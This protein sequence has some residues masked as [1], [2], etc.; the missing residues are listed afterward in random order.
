MRV[1]A[2]VICLIGILPVVAQ[3]Q[4]VGLF[5]NDEQAYEGYTLFGPAQGT[6]V[7][8]I[9]NDGLVVHEW[10]TD[11]RPG[12]MGYLRDNG[13]LVRAARTD[14]DSPI[15]SG[16]LLQEFDWDGN[17]VWEFEPDP[18]T[19]LA[20]H[21]IEPLP[22]GNLLVVAWE[23]KTSA[24]AIAAGRQPLSA[25]EVWPDTILELRPI[26]PND[27]EIV[28]EWHVW[29]HLVQQIDPTADNFGLVWEHPELIDVNFRSTNTDWNHVN[30]V[31]YNP[32]L[33]Q[34]LISV[35][36][37]DEIWVIDHSTTTAEA[38]GHSGGV[39]GKG[40]DLLYRW[41]NPWTYRLGSRSDRKL[42]GQHDAQ[43]IAPGYPG[44]GNI[45]VFNNGH[46]AAGVGYS[47]VDEIVPPLDE[48]GSYSIA[49]GHPYGPPD[50][51]WSFMSTPRE[52]FYSAFISGAQRQPNGNTLICEGMSGH[53]F[54]VTPERDVVW[55]Y[56]N[57]IAIG[58]TTSQ[59]GP[60]AQNFVFK[61]RRYPVDHPA[62]GGRQLTP[63]D[64]IELFFA[65]FPAPDGSLTAFRLS[66]AG[67]TI[68]VEWDASSCA[69][70]DYN[71]IFGDLQQVSTYALSGAQC[72]IGFDGSYVWE[73][74]PADSLYFMVVGADDT[75]IYESSWG[76]DST[77]AE[78][79]G[80]AASFLCGTTTKIVSSTCEGGQGS[81]GAPLS[82]HGSIRGG[83]SSM[84]SR[85]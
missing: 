52:D 56:V 63:G 53:L 66:D 84:E 4:T 14:A 23:F 76:R 6:S 62:I 10:T 54:E 39:S 69:S 35:R 27:A 25:G 28:W 73:D 42:F 72:A 3:E 2:I 30:S 37:F 1:V 75:G 38:A 32:A 17:L 79:H 9:N 36:A 81:A 60:P 24:E 21:D 20:H 59:G 65:P 31:A 8:L 22:N 46:G 55:D 48:A 12:L 83:L 68:L 15:G 45:L 7:Y 85:Y 34:I 41:G 74:M 47:S 57:P 18:Q 58:G 49:P 71:L 64:P 51:S 50:P 19:Y 33:D 13:N 11:Y 80:T 67:E 77:G 26:P 43:W 40:G 29:D 70:S 16:G 44:E 82:D 61:I 5:L 78:R